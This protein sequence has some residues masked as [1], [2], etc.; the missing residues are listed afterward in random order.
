LHERKVTVSELAKEGARAR[1][2]QGDFV[3]PELVADDALA[4]RKK[5][6]GLFVKSCG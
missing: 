5:V 3:P 4:G 1:V 2:H 6:L